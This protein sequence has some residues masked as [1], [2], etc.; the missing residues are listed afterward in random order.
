MF[1]PNIIVKK[2]KRNLSLAEFEEKH[3]DYLLFL[4]NKL[5]QFRNVKEIVVYKGSSKEYSEL[6]DIIYSRSSIVR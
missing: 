3:R 6:C 2:G 1:N 5:I 4:Y